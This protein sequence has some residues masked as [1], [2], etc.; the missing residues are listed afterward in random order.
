MRE[1]RDWL[2]KFSSK[3]YFDI[4]RKE[5]MIKVGYHNNELHDIVW[6]RIF[7]RAMKCGCQLQWVDLHSD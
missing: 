4:R 6:L 7:V 3:K 5:V 2:K 1:D